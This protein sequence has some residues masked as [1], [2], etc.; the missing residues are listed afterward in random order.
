MNHKL[1]LTP[2]DLYRSTDPEHFDFETTDELESLS[3]VIGQPRAVE[4][5]RF[6]MEIDSDGYNIFVLGPSGTGKR[7]I[8]QQFVEQRAESMPVPDDWC[9]VNDFE[10][11]HK[12]KNI[13][14][15]AGMGVQFR[16]D[17]EEL[18]EELQT[19]LSS[20]FE[21]EEYQARRQSVMEEFQER[22][23]EA[24]E[25]LQERARSQ[26]VA[27]IRTPAGLAVA[28][29]RGE[30]VLSPEEL[31]QLPEEERE[32]LQ[33]KVEEI[34]DDLQK[35]MQQ[36]PRWQ[37][38][39]R[40]RLEELNREMANLAVGGLIDELREKYSDFDEVQDHLDAV[41]E[42]VVEHADDFLPSQQENQGSSIMQALQRRAGR[43]PGR[44]PRSLQRYEVNVVVDN[45]DAEGAPVIYED[46]PTYQNLIGR[47]EHQ[48]RMGALHTDFRMIKSGA[49]HR[50][51]GGYL[52]LDVR[53]VLTQPYAWE[54][55]KRALKSE[56]IRIES[57]GQMLSLISTISLEPEPIPLNVKIAL[58]GERILYY[59]LWQLDPEFADLFKVQADFEDEMDRDD[60]QRNL[61]ARFLATLAEE[62][63]LRPLDR[64]GVAR[65]IERSA[66]M[67]GDS[68]KLT[69]H[70]RDLADLLREANYWAGD[71]EHDVITASDVQKA[72]DAQIYRADRLRERT[73]EAIL[74][75]TLLIDTKGEKAAQVNG[76]SV[77]MLGNFAFGRPTRITAR[78][79]LG[80][81]EV[82]DI[83]RE[84]ELGGPIHSKGV[85]I[86]SGFLGAR[87]AQETPLSLSASLVF[88]QSYGGVEG[89]SASSAELYALLSAIADVPIKQSFAVTG[90][91]NQHGQ[92]QAI[93]GVNEKIEG[94]FDICEARGLTGD[95]G[96]LIPQ[97]NVKH[98]MLRR[99]VVEAVE[100]GDFYVYAVSTIDEGIE[101]LTG[102]ESGERGEDG[103]YP[104]GTFNYRV[105]QRLQQLAE[106]R[107]A[108]GESGEEEA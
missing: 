49:L 76:L 96:V 33:E 13:R 38:E 65:I 97:S 45:S 31:Q 108:F 58:F 46:N 21:S 17:M 73:Q 89:D 82:I 66:R 5:L 90:S 7:D 77:L 16:D 41:Q 50:A 27:L 28:P 23:S 72:I 47:V 9:Y 54:G 74:R 87:Y 15:P 78:T 26:G 59:L 93:G 95:Q 36:V 52:V 69:T 101:L 84:V 57:L 86:L 22:Q 35:I 32:E 83:E 56:E 44:G 53:K 70:K 81:G 60:E 19:A 107:E 18:I 12:P 8:I 3:E 6:G 24:F 75:D 25:E 104:E 99:D 88:E 98:L 11:A 40:K 30:E 94:F 68:E 92:V 63:D 62:S 105:E 103:N 39:M 100:A 51:N 10:D 4:A 55:L 64:S 79:R 48:A 91:V 43:E 2:E 34:Q 85:L 20:A 37:R 14:L 106:R 61:Y 102:M 29:V 80:K 71:N 67:V 42:D 1:R